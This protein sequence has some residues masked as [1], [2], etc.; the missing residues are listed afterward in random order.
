MTK[1]AKWPLFLF[2]L[3]SLIAAE[4][5]IITAAS[6]NASDVQTALNSVAADGTTVVIPSGTCT[7]TTGAPSVTY[8]QTYSTVL[9]GQ[10][11]VTCSG[12]PGSTGYSCS[13]T[14]NTTIVDNTSH[15]G[16]DNAALVVTTAASKSFRMTGIT[17]AQNSSSNQSYNGYA[18]N[19][20]GSSQAVRID[21]LHVSITQNNSLAFQTNGTWSGVFDHMYLYSSQGGSGWRDHMTGNGDA[22]WNT[23]TNFGTSGS[24]WRY[25]ESNFIDGM[26]NDDI[27][28]GRMA[29]RFNTYQRSACSPC[30]EPLQTHATGSAGDGRGGRALEIYNNSFLNT[31]SAADTMIEMT[32]GTGLFFG[33]TQTGSWN[34][35]IRVDVNRICAPGVCGANTGYSVSATPAGWGYCGTTSGPS[36]WDQ[37]QDSTGYHCIDQIGMGQGDLLSGTFPNKC[38]STTGCTTYNGT[39]PNQKSEPVYEWM[40]TPASGATY[41]GSLATNVV[42]PNADYYLWCNASSASGCTSFNG[43]VGV[44][45]GALASMPSSCTAGVAYWATDQGNWN[46]SG[47]G[48]QGV[49]YK[50]TATNTWSQF[51]TP[52]TYPHPLTQ[53]STAS[54]GTP[55]PPPTGLQAVVN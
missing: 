40:D 34:N 3:T 50:C 15:S 54:T 47:S 7:W 14:D 48:G 8:T 11:T 37:N 46:Q 53:S 38:D 55:P 13:A 28:G 32:S 49:L 21:H 22:D 27:L 23:A 29:Y 19:I 42:K 51:Y 39:W 41:F 10:T 33:N 20:Q 30:T 12:T 52:Y 36:A 45:S 5:Q 26:S 25:Y 16:G 18:F 35:F 31:G 44:G 9:Q 6:C 17:F 2:L 43:T 24:G 4:A 1:L